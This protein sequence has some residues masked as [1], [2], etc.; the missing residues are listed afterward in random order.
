MDPHVFVDRG[1]HARPP[2]LV[3]FR[4]HVDVEGVVVHQLLLQGDQ[5]AESSSFRSAKPK[6]NSSGLATRERIFLKNSHQR[7]TLA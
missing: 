6:S 5:G 1:P 7:C 3:K 4:V 2:V